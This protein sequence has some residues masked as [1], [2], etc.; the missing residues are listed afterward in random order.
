MLFR[1]PDHFLTLPEVYDFDPL[2][3]GLTA[4]TS[5][6]G[7][8][9]GVLGTQAQVW[10]EH[11]ATPE[12]VQYLAYPRLC[13]LAETAWSTG[14]RDFGEFCERLA[15]HTRRLRLLGVPEMS[16]QHAMSTHNGTP[17]GGAGGMTGGVN[18]DRGGEVGELAPA[19][20]SMES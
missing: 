20:E 6:S 4:V 3:G 19:A 16:E 7:S 1:S 8:G 14:P 5:R 13:A 10:S 12:H 11:V 9:G 18:G 15:V 17:G 2:A